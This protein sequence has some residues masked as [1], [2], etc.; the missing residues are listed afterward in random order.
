MVDLKDRVEEELERKLGRVDEEER[1]KL[2]YTYKKMTD[3]G[4]LPW[5]QL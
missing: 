4:E 1:L 5:Q 2:L 3:K